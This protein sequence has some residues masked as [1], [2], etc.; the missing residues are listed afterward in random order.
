MR[1]ATQ[2]VACFRL[3]AQNWDGQACICKLQCHV[4][5]VINCLDRH[6]HKY[7]RSAPAGAAA[8]AAAG[9]WRETVP[10]RKAPGAAASSAVRQQ[11]P[12]AAASGRTTPGV[13]LRA[14]RCAR[15]SSARYSVRH[16]VYSGLCRNIQLGWSGHREG[17]GHEKVLLPFQGT[18]TVL[19][20]SS[21]ALNQP[22]QV[23]WDIGCGP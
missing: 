12:G 8:A 6:R 10:P 4:A 1:T 20:K 22:E 16:E 14:M 11:Q 18:I 19:N 23:L 15:R 13:A 17:K 21:M 2:Q 5:A 3:Q 9:S 7:R